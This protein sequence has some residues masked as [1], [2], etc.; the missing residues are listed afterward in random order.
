VRKAVDFT[1]TALT[2]VFASPRQFWGGGKPILKASAEY[3]SS[4]DY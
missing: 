3:F 2:D 4:K 1:F